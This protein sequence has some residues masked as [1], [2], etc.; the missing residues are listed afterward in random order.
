MHRLGWVIPAGAASSGR[1]ARGA[2][3]FV[4]HWRAAA[5]GTQSRWTLCPSRRRVPAPFQL[6][7]CAGLGRED[8]ADGRE[9]SGDAG[10]VDDEEDSEAFGPDDD[11]VEEEMVASAA[12]DT[13]MELA[14]EEGDG[15]EEEE[16][17]QEEDQ[18]GEEDALEGD[19]A[20]HYLQCPECAVC[21]LVH[22]QLLE[23]PR[24]CRCTNCLHEFLA[25]LRDLIDAE[26]VVS[27]RPTMGAR[28]APRNAKSEA[29]RER[30]S[31][32][33]Q[34]AADSPAGNRIAEDAAGQVTPDG[35]SLEPEPTDVTIFVGN[36]AYDATEDDLYA[37]FSPYGDLLECYLIRHRVTAKC[38]G[39]GFV[40][41]A[42][43]EDA[44]V[45]L[46]E[47]QGTAI[48]GRDLS[49]DFARPQ[50]IRS[51]EQPRSAS[52]SEGLPSHSRR[53]SDNSGIGGESMRSRRPRRMPPAFASS[54][55]VQP[56]PGAAAARPDPHSPA[57]WQPQSGG[58]PGS[59]ERPV[60]R[61][62][63]R[64]TDSN[65]DTAR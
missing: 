27:S 39:Y 33:R 16:E 22:P 48:L 47:L 9:A 58:A 26:T 51:P 61:P 42:R 3:R 59:R 62:W 15:A 54:N 20:E 43:R 34:M 18:E 64:A 19:N 10:A 1:R 28:P 53:G 2:V 7:L 49:L 37:A 11:E 17:D 30:L 46:S 4:K 35:S 12:T 25:S 40:T 41:F 50:R 8:R 52:A 63:R 56:D 31:S 23:T 13:E 57:Y 29:V 32:A 14:D 44:L 65:R 38:L 45:A 24:V 36:V 5:L 60:R 55:A 6:R 21:Y